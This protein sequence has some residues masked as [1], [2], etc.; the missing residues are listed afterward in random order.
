MSSAR[1]ASG[2]RAGR[3]VGG[4]LTAVFGVPFVLFAF[5]ALTSRFGSGDPHGYGMIFG[6]L[7]ALAAGLLT[8]LC[9]PLTFPSGRRG[10]AVGW[11]MG[12]FVVIAL[13]LII[14]LLTA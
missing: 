14:A 13:A 9:L 8:A 4:A 7:L 2:G 5:V 11:S 6:T 1:S 3:I 12:G 10:T